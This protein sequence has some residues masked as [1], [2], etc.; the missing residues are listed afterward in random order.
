MHN[1]RNQ[2]PIPSA[3]DLLSNI[4]FDIEEGKIW[5]GENR[6]VLFHAGAI[7]ALRQELINTLGLERTKAIMMRFGYESGMRDAEFARNTRPDLTTQEAFLS[8]PQLHQ[9]E[10]VVHVRPIK[11]EMDIEKGH[12]YGEF[13]WHGSYEAE[14][15]LSDIGPSADPVCW[16][17]LGY[18]SGYTSY[19]MRRKIYFKETQ[20]VACGD[21]HCTNIGKPADEWDEPA[22]I[23][24]YLEAAPI[25]EQLLAL[26]SEV[27]YLKGNQQAPEEDFL[28]N[29]VGKS[30]A[31]KDMCRMIARASG[32]NVTT[33][34]IGET[35]VGKEAVAR[36]L[37]LGGDRMDKP[38]IAVNCATLPPDLI[39]AEL[40]GVEKGAYTGAN[41]SR[42]GKFERAD[43]GTL[44]LDEVAELSPRAQAALLRVLQEGELE[45]VGGTKVIKID[46]RIITATHEDLKEK[47]EAGKFRADLFYR[48]NVFPIIIPPLRERLEDIPLL[49][50][51]FI[52]KFHD[53]YN[54]LTLGISDKALNAL[55]NHNWPGNVREL[56]NMIERGIILT[57]NSQ[58]IVLEN[59]FPMLGGTTTSLNQINTAG[60]L[61]KSEDRP[62]E[63]KLEEHAE[64]LLGDEGFQ[65]D[66]LEEAL[67][68]TAMKK[69]DGNV[70][71]AARL[72]GITR[73]ALAYKLKNK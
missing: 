28:I 35:G 34:L 63:N 47:V 69:T 38:F 5:L 61:N 58:Q 39:E 15:H 70:S 52:D 55:M 21:S 66:A 23:E 19:Y 14:V 50:T 46:V 16:T 40:F 31:F 3:K 7:G 53:K 72:L 29:S 42:E 26:R 27:D 24:Q 17:L 62:T 11:I 44:F 1:K 73:P 22:E 10:G 8:G 9:I 18:A 51:H 37:R 25:V 54:K 60:A 33:M 56:E 49:V 12:F 2:L 43:K 48:L 45:R 13:D 57:D 41:S 6:M 65:L 20:C 32:S 30:A 59:I 71:K 67:V 68:D 64:R 36:G 4:K